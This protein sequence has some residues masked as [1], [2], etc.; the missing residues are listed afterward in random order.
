M[1]YLLILFL[2]AV[3]PVTAQTFNSGSTGADGA[4]NLTTPGTVVFDPKTFSPPLDPDGDGIYHFT[5]ITIAAGVTV[6]LRGD[7]INVPVIWLAQG[8]VQINGVID[9]SGQDGFSANNTTQRT[10]TIPGA[11]GYAGGYPGVGSNPAGAGLGPAGG[12]TS[13]IP[14]DPNYGES[15]GFLGN[16]FAVPLTGGSGGG[17]RFSWAGGAGGG[18]ILVAS[19]VSIG[20]AGQIKANG[21]ARTSSTG[22]AGAGGAIR[23]VAPIV[24]I[25]G[26]LNVSGGASN[27]CGPTVGTL[28]GVVRVEAFQI[29]SLSVSGP[30]YTATPYGLFISSTGSP[31]LRV[32]SVG[33]VPVATSPTGTFTIPDVTVNSS[34]PLPVAIEAAN[35]PIGTVVTLTIFSENGPD[36][37][38]QSTALAGTLAA[39]TATANVTLPSGFS[40]GF[41][42]ATFTQP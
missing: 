29:G 25:T 6:R 31:A 21:G 7:I 10:N 3:L 34:S 41:L 26:T 17:G 20:G 37:V 22:G 28:N 39:S 38:A 11:G 42:K 30:L 36:I 35:V 8:A 23:L 14:G 15:G 18:A 4:L 32:V 24:N 1:K 12:R 13:C 9:S 19:S 16:Q 5:T 33:G 40:K 2:C 27:Y